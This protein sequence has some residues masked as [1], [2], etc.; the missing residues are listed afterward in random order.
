MVFN[1]YIAPIYLRCTHWF[2]IFTSIKSFNQV[3]HRHAAALDEQHNMDGSGESVEN[4]IF[5]NADY[6]LAAL[7][8][9]AAH[10]EMQTENLLACLVLQ[11]CCELLLNFQ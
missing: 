5:F 7:H 6:F 8:I 2:V 1:P 10:M 4:V 11:I 9:Y 3:Y